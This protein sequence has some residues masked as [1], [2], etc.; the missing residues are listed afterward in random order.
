MQ[1]TTELYAI[2]THSDWACNGGAWGLPGHHRIADLTKAAGISRLY[3]RTHNGGQA[4]YPSR[5][6]RI[7]DGSVYRDP[8]FKGFATL[9]KSYFA[10]A[11]YLDYSKWDQVADMAAV[12]AEAGLETCHWY[13]VFEDDHG[14][15]LTSSFIE[16]H[17]DMRCTLR[18]GQQVKGCLDFW[19]PEVRAYK[20]SV[21][22]ELL[23]RPTSRLLLD[24][25][26][27]NGTPSADADGNYRYGYNPE[28]MAA[29]K[30]RTGLDPLEITAGTPEWELWLD[31]NAEPLT[32]FIR[33]VVQRLRKR[34]IPLDLLVWAVDPRRWKALDIR[35]L[36]TEGL[37]DSIQ[38]G[39]HSYAY[40]PSDT[41]MQ[42]E[43][44][45]SALGEGS[46]VPVYPTICAYNQLPPVT[47]DACIGAAVEL[48]TGAV[49]LHENNHII[50]CPISDRLRA[51]KYRKPHC[52]REVVATFGKKSAPA[53]NGFI[54]CHDVTG[55]SCDQQTAFT[56]H[57]DDD[58]LYIDVTCAERN[59]SGLL[60]VPQIGKENYNGNMLGARTFN[61]YESVQVLIDVD[62]GHEDYINFIVD[63]SGEKLCGSRLDETWN[64]DWTVAVDI[65][66]AEW[67][68]EFRLPWAS[69]GKQPQPG[70]VFGFQIFRIQNSPRELSAWFCTTGRRIN[71]MEF[72]HL[73]LSAGQG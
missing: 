57:W 70:A 29:F 4:K 15:H 25:L 28:I 65:G 6:C 42:V 50:E 47:V 10:Y 16:Q 5:I 72:G 26:R 27:R 12:G 34:A 59:V 18:D 22:D 60:P 9:P 73:R 52:Q 61:P 66:K 32:E 58:A 31:F 30:Q 7:S 23:E 43:T 45:R 53:N 71:P 46:Q 69:L 24:F 11:R 51:W 56:V 54:K 20:L 2:G 1:A 67:R 38:V 48:G 63:P 37:I 14:G 17:P 55:A 8:N 3:W 39:T 44:V 49:V 33:E 41:R 62:H 19:Y 36:A 40:S 68:A 13:T 64:R 35:R 21:V